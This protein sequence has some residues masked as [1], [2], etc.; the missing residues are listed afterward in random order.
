[1]VVALLT[2]LA[3]AAAV[4]GLA[5]R[6]LLT[7]ISS[8]DTS[9]LKALYDAC[10]PKAMAIAQRLLRN[11]AEAEDVVQETFVEVWKRAGQY[12]ER[13][14]NVV[15]WVCTIA[16]TRSIDRLRSLGSAARAADSAAAE[17]KDDVA[18]APLELAEA[19]RD[20]ERVT[21]AMATLPPEQRRALELAYFDGL[22]QREIAERTGDPLGTVKTRVRLAMLKLGEL[23][24]EPQEAA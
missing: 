5:D 6:E 17:V 2:F 11:R 20:R 16:R 22:T 13:R 18:P 1:M 19:R 9:A 7:R 10:A 23:L 24:A 12:D 8:R 15:S 21:A 3:L 14:G 4:A